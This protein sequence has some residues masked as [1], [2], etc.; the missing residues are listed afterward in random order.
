[1]DVRTLTVMAGLAAMLLPGETDA[2]GVEPS[3]RGLGDLPG[4]G[5]YS[6]SQDVSGDG[7]TIVG[8]SRATSV[9]YRAFY[10]RPDT[11]MVDF[12]VGDRSYAF[13]TSYDGSVIVGEKN[14]PFRWSALSGLEYL[15]SSSGSANGVSADGNVVVG[16][17]GGR[18]FR[19][20]SQGGL[21]E[22]GNL[23]GGSPGGSASG[24]S[25]D[26]NVVVGDG[27]TPT[28]TYVAFR[29]TEQ[30]GMVELGCLPSSPNGWTRAYGVSGNGLVVLGWSDTGANH[31][32]VRWTYIA[33]VEALGDPSGSIRQSYAAD[34]SF[35]GSIIVGGAETSTY[36]WYATIWDAAHGTRWLKDVLVNDYG[37]DLTGWRLYGAYGISD[38][39]TVIT[40]G[41][42]NP[43]GAE[44][45]WVAVIPEPTTFSI[46]MCAAALC[47]KRRSLRERR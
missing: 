17:A 19:W 8:R 3:F 15:S 20:T 32:A 43:A 16:D 39:G 42:I 9:G 14:R 41:G 22:L 44:E 21:V 1:M 46:L 47:L 31:K 29:W 25:S 11:G 2:Y 10:W 37:L 6:W 28:R 40:G 38:D 24:V 27:S 36:Y 33:G 26:G 34:A 45:A 18:P 30:E 5:F 7:T 12:G 13:Q 4:S 23:P 35:D